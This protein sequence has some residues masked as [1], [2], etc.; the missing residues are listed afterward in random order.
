[1]GKDVT[2]KGAIGVVA[3]VNLIA[4][5]G[6]VGREL[7]NIHHNGVGLQR[8][9]SELGNASQLSGGWCAR[10][11]GVQLGVLGTCACAVTVN[12]AMLAGD[13]ATDVVDGVYIRYFCHR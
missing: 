8:R 1:M 10:G 6:A 9:L 2:A 5:R 12:G 3:V 11:R 7:F 4:P 13:F